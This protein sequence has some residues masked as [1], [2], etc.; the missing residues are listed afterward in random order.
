MRAF[1]APG[2]LLGNARLEVRLVYSGFL[3]LAF[4]GMLTTAAFQLRH[5][6]P[7]PADIVAHYRGGE[8]AGEMTFPK[9]VRELVEITH[10]HAFVMGL[11]YLVMAHLLLATRAPLW[12]KQTAI[13]VGFAGLFGDIACMWL[14]RFVSPLFAHL[15]LASWVG[16]WLGF[17]AYVYYP[18]QDMWGPDGRDEPE[19]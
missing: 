8:R 16:E 19:D 9:T 6:G 4:V 15:Q 2:Y 3:V 14:V 7:T 12:I 13:V 17:A 10:F 5:V 1:G 11:V 18:L